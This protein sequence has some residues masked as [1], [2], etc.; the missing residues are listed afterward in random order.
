M[1]LV[2]ILTAQNPGR[3]ISSLH[4]FFLKRVHTSHFSPTK[5]H[6]CV[7]SIIIIDMPTTS[8]LLLFYYCCW[9]PYDPLSDLIV[10]RVL[11]S[12]E[13]GTQL[14]WPGSPSLLTTHEYCL[15]TVAG[16]E[17]NHKALLKIQRFLDYSSR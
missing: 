10:A 17:K 1:M 11:K 2:E 9:L 14:A 13:H 7:R 12:S 16:T 3:P 15:S 4:Y 5:L 6:V 8:T